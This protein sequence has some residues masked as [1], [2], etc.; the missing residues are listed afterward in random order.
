MPSKI[1]KD[2]N[3]TNHKHNNFFSNS[4]KEFGVSTDK[5]KIY[6]KILELTRIINTFKNFLSKIQSGNFN[7]EVLIRMQKIKTCVNFME[8]ELTELKN[9]I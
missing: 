6:K 3:N 9:R 8:I 1:R 7:T 5:K 4:Y 2:R